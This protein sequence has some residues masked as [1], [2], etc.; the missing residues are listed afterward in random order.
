MT[1]AELRVEVRR[2]PWTIAGAVLVVLSC[3]LSAGSS[4]TALRAQQAVQDDVEARAAERCESNRTTRT[5]QEQLLVG[6]VERLG[7]RQSVIDEVHAYYDD[8]PPLPDCD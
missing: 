6:L 8:L 5:E 7:G 2:R 1:L 4:C 3:L